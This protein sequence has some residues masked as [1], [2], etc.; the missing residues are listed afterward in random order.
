MFF[1]NLEFCFL[2]PMPG[3]RIAQTKIAE[4][5]TTIS[6]VK[7]LRRLSPKRH[8]SERSA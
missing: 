4:C 3:S 6:I 2:V 8:L 5:I 7:T 1:D